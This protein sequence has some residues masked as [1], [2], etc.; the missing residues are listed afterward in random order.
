MYRAPAS[1]TVPCE[2]CGLPRSTK[3][4]VCPH[5]AGGGRARIELSE[6]TA[7]QLKN[8]R[9][10]MAGPWPT[11]V[12]ALVFIFSFPVVVP[13]LIVHW[14][15]ARRWGRIPYFSMLVDA[16]IILMFSLRV[17]S[18][19]VAAVI[20]I[21][22]SAV[23]LFRAVARGRAD[24]GIFLGYSNAVAMPLIFGGGLFLVGALVG[25]PSQVLRGAVTPSTP[26]TYALKEALNEGVPIPKHVL[27]K[28]A[29]VRWSDRVTDG[30]G[31]TWSPIADSAGRVWVVTKG[32]TTAAPPAEGLFL[33]MPAAD[34]EELH[35]LAPDAF[36]DAASVRGAYVIVSAPE[37]YESFGAVPPPDGVGWKWIGLAALGLVGIAFATWRALDEEEA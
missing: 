6:L 4:A 26:T 23:L 27:F 24:S 29:T 28:G 14:V 9:T 13:S 8:D 2:L 11:W 25:L 12:R 18:L 22:S 1:E 32:G 33:R 17:A 35:R 16:V 30:A 21:A 36:G 19:T 15:F 10:W 37:L 31:R 5:C 7:E 20:A 3:V 34:D